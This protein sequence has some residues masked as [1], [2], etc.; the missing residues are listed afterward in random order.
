MKITTED[1]VNAIVGYYD[2]LGIE[3]DSKDWKRISKKGTGDNIV[4]KFQ[5]KQTDEEVYVRANTEEILEVSDEEIGNVIKK[6]DNF[7]SSKSTDA[8]EFVDYPFVKVG[9]YATV[10]SKNEFSK[11][12][13]R[14]SDDLKEEQDEE[15]Y[16]EFTLPA[17]TRIGIVEPTYNHDQIDIIM[18][19]TK[20]MKY[21]SYDSS[22]TCDGIITFEID[23][24]VGYVPSQE[25]VDVMEDG[26][27]YFDQAFDD[28]SENMKK[29]AGK[30]KLNHLLSGN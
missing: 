17:G 20:K 11:W 15:G 1:C 23:D 26:D 18:V 28:N 13:F 27:D 5:N 10:Y 6:F 2:E 24:N 19:V 21:Y 4:R 14:P 7:K 3:T 29:L 25:P 12:E 16:E 22:L 8:N 30:F 9:K